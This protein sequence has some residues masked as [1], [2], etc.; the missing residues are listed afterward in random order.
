MSFLHLAAALIIVASLFSY[1]N[2][3]ILRIPRAV[4]LLLGGLTAALALTLISRIFPNSQLV[5]I[6]QPAIH[7]I[8]V[9]GLILHGIL[10]F[11]IF[12]GA[13]E[14]DLGVL[15]DR[16]GGIALLATG[17]VVIATALVAAG[18]FALASISGSPLPF[19]GCLLF[20]AII[21]PTD[22][23]AVVAIMRDL[24]VRKT[25]E[26][27]MSS[28][29][30]FNDGV[31]IAIFSTILSIAMH[32]AMPASMMA[33]TAA[34]IL[35]REAGGGLVAGLVLAYVVYRML[36]EIDD[37]NVEVLMSFSLVLGIILLSEAMHVSAPI[38][39]AAAGLLIGHRARRHAM[40]EATRIALDTL[41]SFT[42]HTLNALLFFVVG[43]EAFAIGLPH[44][45]DVAEIAAII[46]IVV[47]ARFLSVWLAARM[48][49]GRT[50]PMQSILALTWG[51][52]RGG[53]SVALA[54]SLPNLP[55]RT[56]ILNATYMTVIFSIAVQG[57]TARRVFRRLGIEA[58]ADGA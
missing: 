31:A 21:A 16:A 37:P 30:L 57:L 55:Y 24:K 48:L 47:A 46:V 41:W 26:V 23:V 53:V 38:G 8:D 35:V 13:L 29:S 36:R 50:I 6:G 58:Q 15:R 19:V 20:G 40:E 52:L 5:A 25:I 12:A 34:V 33:R 4:G 44:L 43:L 51:G 49:P 17:G 27:A 28:E 42:D 39:C 45:R 3:V 22:P 32:P 54:L 11:I 10:G 56:F 14:I 7:G 18:V 1:L 9:S 2:T